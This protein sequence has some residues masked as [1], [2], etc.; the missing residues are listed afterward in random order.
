MPN[1]LHECYGIT[2]SGSRS[3]SVSPVSQSVIS[4]TSLKED[5][6]I[7]NDYL[8]TKITKHGYSACW[9]WCID[10]SDTLIIVPRNSWSMDVIA[11][12]VTSGTVQG[13][14][15]PVSWSA[16]KGMLQSDAGRCLYFNSPTNEWLF[17]QLSTHDTPAGNNNNNNNH[18]SNSKANN[19]NN[20][21]NNSNDNS[22]SNSYHSSPASTCDTNNTTIPTKNT[23]NV[24]DQ[25][26][27]AA[28]LEAM[29]SLNYSADFDYKD[30]DSGSDSGN[31]RKYE[32]KEWENESAKHS[33]SSVASSMFHSFD[34]LDGRDGII[35]AKSIN[36]I[37]NVSDDVGVSE[38]VVT[39][40]GNGKSEGEEREE[41]NE[42]GNE[43]DI[44]LKGYSESSRSQRSRLSSTDADDMFFDTFE[45]LPSS[46]TRPSPIPSN[47]FLSPLPFTTTLGD[48]LKD[49]KKAAAVRF[50]IPASAENSAS[51]TPRLEAVALAL[52][53]VSRI[54]I[55]LRH[56]D[57][58]VSLA[59]PL[60]DQT[61]DE[62]KEVFDE[63]RLFSNVSHRSAVF[64]TNNNENN[65]DEV[66]TKEKKLNYDTKIKEKGLEK[67]YNKPYI[68][69][70]E[71]NNS[72]SGYHGK[73]KGRG[74]RGYD[75]ESSGKEE[76][77]DGEDIQRCVSELNRE[78][79]CCICFKCT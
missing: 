16:P 24:L 36:E 58:F 54:V 67:G 17:S 10:L 44:T 48:E 55:S 23:A 76:D 40:A 50:S 79:C 18:N 30:S 33:A 5:I 77:G 45:D 64:Y 22:N 60:S 59:G 43:V 12:R 37:D 52:S 74:S 28:A 31:T 8:K 41:V 47:S 13:T 75:V 20:S 63:T 14:Y 29:I 69:I 35:S 53:A 2:D 68:N 78:E 4:E 72:T 1:S 9:E 56:T 32:G 71:T 15:V 11:V 34:A 51:V 66:D 25:A 42:E 49:I 7:V 39:S 70:F 3:G 38:R 65:N 57:V 73:G 62:E 19:N 61:Q 21:N 46:P 27:T 6:K 26:T